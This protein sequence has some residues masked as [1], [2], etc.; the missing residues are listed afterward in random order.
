MQVVRSFKSDDATHVGFGIRSMLLTDQG[1]SGPIASRLAGL[2]SKVEVSQELFSAL[3]ALIEDPAG[4]GLFVMDCDCF[5]GIGAGRKAVALLG[6]LARRVPVILV[7]AE[8]GQQVF[9]ENR[10]EPTMLRLPLSA[11]SLR[12]GFQHALRDR[13]TMRMF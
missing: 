3:E 4:Y 11:V 7:S 9:P 2:G 8:C 10:G 5:G 12:V 1:E 6:G 13:L